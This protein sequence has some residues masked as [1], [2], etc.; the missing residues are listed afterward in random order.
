MG[1]SYFSTSLACTRFLHILSIRLQ[2]LGHKP[3]LWQSQLKFFP[4]GYS[5]PSIDG[6]VHPPPSSSTSFKALKSMMGHIMSNYRVVLHMILHALNTSVCLQLTHRSRKY[7]LIFIHPLLGPWVWGEI[8]EIERDTHNTEKVLKRQIFL[9][10]AV[11]KTSNKWQ[12]TNI[13]SNVG[14]TGFDLLMVNKSSTSPN[15]SSLVHASNGFFRSCL[16]SQVLLPDHL[17]W[18]EISRDIL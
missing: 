9:F 7:K 8:R 2:L 16:S 11:G 5:L 17:Y 18:R 10:V 1:V 6:L 3:R 12:L 4:S 14:I 13:A 15:S